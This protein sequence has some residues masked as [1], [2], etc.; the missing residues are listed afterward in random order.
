MAESVILTTPLLWLLYGIALTLCLYDKSQR[1]T[2]GIFTAVSAV[3][4]IVACAV[5][6]ILGAGMSEVITVLLVFLLL[7]LEGWK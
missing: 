7:G 3:L 5:S 2:G 1:A 6:L 4:T